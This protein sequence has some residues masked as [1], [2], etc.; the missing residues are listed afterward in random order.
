MPWKNRWSDKTT[1]VCAI[2]SEVT[3]CTDTFDIMDNTTKKMYLHFI[4]NNGGPY[5]LFVAIER[6]GKIYCVRCLRANKK[7]YY[8]ILVDECEGA[9]LRD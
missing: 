8:E 7:A 5:V 4:F 2:C 3:P 9:K 1:C 6:E